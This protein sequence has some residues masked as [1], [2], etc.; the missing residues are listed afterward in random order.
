MAPYVD[1]FACFL[2]DGM[3]QAMLAPHLQKEANA[4]Q[5]EVAM[6]FCIMG[7]TFS[8]STPIA[9]YVCYKT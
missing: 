2:G 6:A 3:A 8:I 5:T 7:F 4:T 1:A 9:G